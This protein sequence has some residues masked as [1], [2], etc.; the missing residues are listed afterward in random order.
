MDL[1]MFDRCVR[2]AAEGAHTRFLFCF[3][4]LAT[5]DSPALASHTAAVPFRALLKRPNGDS[6][7]PLDSGGP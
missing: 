5:L 2:V 4:W 7:G 1:H 6:G 3:V